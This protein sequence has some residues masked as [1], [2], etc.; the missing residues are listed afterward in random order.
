MRN[1]IRV[2]EEFTDSSAFEHINPNNVN[3]IYIDSETEKGK[4]LV[5]VEF[6]NAKVVDIP[7]EDYKEA[8]RFIKRVGDINA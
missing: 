4:P 6:T 1:F 8:H 3:R 5:T 2:Y 7:F